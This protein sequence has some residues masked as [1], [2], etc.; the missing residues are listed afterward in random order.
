[1]T[2]HNDMPA[3]TPITY[4]KGNAI[5]YVAG[6]VC[7]KIKEKIEVSKHQFKEALLLCMMDMCDEDDE[8]ISS[9]D[10]LHAIDRGE[11][12][13]VSEATVMLF[14]EIE[15]LVRKIFNKEALQVTELTCNLKQKVI[16]SALTDENVHFHWCFISTDIEDGKATIL[17]KMIIE[18][19]VTIRGFSFVK[20]FMELYKQATKKSTQK[21]K[22]LRKKIYNDEAKKME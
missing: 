21:S 20:S 22:A 11:L 1:M 19:H 4:E 8:T 15:L 7:R 13:R 10:W 14:H 12:C 2:T 16:E 5:R 18:L 6:Y 3:I 9:A 17:L